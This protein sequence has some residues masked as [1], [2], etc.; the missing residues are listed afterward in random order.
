MYVC[1]CHGI[2]DKDIRAAA[3]KGVDS[4]E[5]LSDQLK[6]ATCCGRCADCARAVLHESIQVTRIPDHAEA[7]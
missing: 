5:A 2:T 1:I 7:A 6:V 4:M 3:R